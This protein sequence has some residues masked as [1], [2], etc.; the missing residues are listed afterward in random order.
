MDEFVS[1]CFSRINCIKVKHLVVI[2]IGVHGVIFVRVKL[3]QHGVGLVQG[4][5]S[6]GCPLEGSGGAVLVGDDA[7]RAGTPVGR[8]GHLR[9]EPVDGVLPLGGVLD[10]LL[11]D[12]GGLAAGRHQALDCLVGPATVGVLAVLDEVDQSVVAEV[13]RALD[14]QL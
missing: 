4:D 6:G 8:L 2:N 14:H 11:L 12:G 1:H 13:S 10:Q 9:L 7:V 5:L 3:G